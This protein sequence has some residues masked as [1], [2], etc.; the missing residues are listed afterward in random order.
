MG[1]HPSKLRIRSK[2]AGLGN[3]ARPTTESSFLDLPYDIR[4]MVYEELFLPNEPPPPGSTAILRVCKE[5]YEE[6]QP[7]FLSKCLF[8][9][10]PLRLSCTCPEQSEIPGG[11]RDVLR[12]NDSVGQLFSQTEWQNAMLHEFSSMFR[13]NWV[14]PPQYHIYAE[15]VEH[16]EPHWRPWSHINKLNRR[17]KKYRF[18]GGS[19][20]IDYYIL[21]NRR[22]WNVHGLVTACDMIRHNTLVK[23]LRRLG[24]KKCARIKHLRVLWSYD[25]A[26]F[27]GPSFGVLGSAGQVSMLLA[28]LL[29][30]SCLPSLSHI[31]L[32]EFP[33]R[34]NKKP[35][36]DWNAADL[37][38]RNDE[39]EH[40]DNSHRPGASEEV[41]ALFFARNEDLET[42]DRTATSSGS[43]SMRPGRLFVRAVDVLVDACPNVSAAP[44]NDMAKLLKLQEFRYRQWP[45]HTYLSGQPYGTEVTI[46][47]SRYAE[48]IEKPGIKSEV[49]GISTGTWAY[50]G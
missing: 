13:P 35:F 28:S 31:S 39:L 37:I 44:D 11:L 46:P 17:K 45:R 40:S 26:L 4:L 47:S 27:D 21:L 18:D 9:I 23:G 14:V 29:I 49:D 30:Q 32:Q 12:M 10:L 7:V 5:I 2:T 22:P 16:L 42:F 15:D 43:F 34:G 25:H 36:E 38:P 33:R 24:E 3:P 20:S 50:K 41:M 1:A 6:S 48:I 19:Q 8:T